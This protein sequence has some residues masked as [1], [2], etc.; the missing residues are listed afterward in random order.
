MQI[1]NSAAEKNNRCQEN[2]LST[3]GGE[4]SAARASCKPHHSVI[5]TDQNFI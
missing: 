2:N 4:S 5:H 3:G 1:W